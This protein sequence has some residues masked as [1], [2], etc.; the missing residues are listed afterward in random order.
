MAWIKVNHI[1]QN[2]VNADLYFCLFPIEFIIV[3]QFNF[4]FFFL[5][6]RVTQTSCSFCINPSSGFDDEQAVW[7]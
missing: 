2:T 3:V 1:L 4:F 7:V 6:F 5:R